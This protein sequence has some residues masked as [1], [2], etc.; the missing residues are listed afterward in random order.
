MRG[1]PSETYPGEVGVQQLLDEADWLTWRP[2]LPRFSRTAAKGGQDIW[3]AFDIIGLRADSPV[4]GVQVGPA[5][6]GARKKREVQRALGD[7][8]VLPLT[9]HLS[10]QLWLWNEGKRRGPRWDVW[11][12]HMIA[13]GLGVKPDWWLIGAV[14]REGGSVMPEQVWPLS[15]EVL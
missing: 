4:L 14:K 8:F 2:P 5:S 9:H 10:T 13:E 7:Y 12:L 15:K 3:G 6:K 1:V 11:E